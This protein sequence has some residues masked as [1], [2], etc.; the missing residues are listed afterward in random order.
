MHDNL[1]YIN[2]ANRIPNNCWH[3]RL[4]TGS[5]SDSIS[6]APMTHEIGV[7]A[8]WALRISLAIDAWKICRKRAQFTSHRP[9]YIFII[10]FSFYLPL[11]PYTTN[12]VTRVWIYV[13]WQFVAIVARPSFQHL[14]TRKDH[15]DPLYLTAC[16]HT[17]QFNPHR[18]RQAGF[19]TQTFPVHPPNAF[20]AHATQQ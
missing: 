9:F 10:I 16:C 3:L 8:F 4:L 13:L 20:G 15:V 14:I 17:P 11:Y 12:G 2:W 19:N 1:Y 5:V 7:L 18:T 6:R